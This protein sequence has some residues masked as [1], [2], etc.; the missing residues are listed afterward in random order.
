MKSQFLKTAVLLFLALALLVAAGED[1]YRQLGIGRDAKPVEIKRAFRRLALRYHP[2]KNRDNPER[3]QQM[4]TK[5]ANAYEVLSDPKKRQIYDLGGEENVKNQGHGNGGGREDMGFRDMF[6]EFFGGARR[7]RRRD[8]G[9][10]FHFEAGSQRHRGPGFFKDFGDKQQQQ[11]NQPQKEKED[12]KRET[13]KRRK[14]F[15][16]SR[17]LQLDMA[18]ITR[19][20]RSGQAWYIYFFQSNDPGLLRLADKFIRLAE[21]SEDIFYVGAIN[22]EEQEELCEEFGVSATPRLYFFRSGDP[23]SKEEV[24]GHTTVDELHTR[25]IRSI[26]SFVDVVNDRSYDEF[27]SKFP[28]RIKVLY[29]GVSSTRVP[30]LLKALSS[31]YKNRLHFGLASGYS[32]TKRYKVSQKP[33]LLV[34]DSADEEGTVYPG[35]MKK[36]KISAFLRPFRLRRIKTKSNEVRQLTRALLDRGACKQDDRQMCLILF[37][38]SEFAPAVRQLADLTGKYASDNINFYFVSTQAQGLAEFLKAFPKFDSLKEKLLIYKPWRR[39]YAVFKGEFTGEK[40]SAFI[41]DVLA[42]GRAT[43]VADPEHLKLL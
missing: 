40:L 18:D 32:L 23:K 28:E 36:D 12:N 10:R 6:N 37:A 19:F 3:A 27:M 20:Y 33:C 14:P 8:N 11:Q 31:E 24:A 2:D 17:V 39:R 29:F 15:E 26:D 9:P 34:V 5:I 7:E 25:A 1:Y 41:D 16:G 21:K 22:C 43:E 30:P 4:F 35:E 42:G 13:E 38:G